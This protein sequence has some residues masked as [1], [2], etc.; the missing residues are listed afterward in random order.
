MIIDSRTVPDDETIKTDVCIV[1][2]GT[3]GITL[4][5]EF[6]DQ[7]F[8][9]C[10][11]E[12]GGLKPDRETQA[13]YQGE[14]IGHPYYS[15]D[16]AR[17]RYFGGTTNR[18]H[19]PIGDDC[20]GVRMHPLDAID[21]EKRNWV[22][23]SGWPFDKSHLD[24]YYDKA[25]ENC[26]ITPAAYG[27]TDW[28]NPKK[29]PS[30]PFNR[31]RVKTVIFK[32]GSRH[33]F[34]DGYATEVAQAENIT[35]YL[36]SNVIEIETN[37]TAHTITRL[38]VACLEGN[39]FWVRA[40]RI[41]L[42]AGAIEIPRLLLSSNRT[43]KAGLGNQHDLV[44][45]FFME[46]PHFSSGFFVPSVPGIFKFTNLYEHIHR[47]NGVPIIGKLSLSEKVLRQE[48]LLNYV[49][50]LS[51]RIA[52][53]TSLNQFLYPR[54]ES[55]SVHSY[56]ALRFAM[57]QRK[58]PDDLGSH[59]RN[60]FSGF[61]DFTV[62]AYRNIK[63]RVLRVLDKRR[64]RLFRLDNMTEQAPNPDSRVTLGSDRDSLGQ[65]RVRL[66]WRLSDFDM[67]SFIKSQE[68]VDQELRRAG[69]G[70][71]YVKPI[72][73]IPPNQITGGWHHMGTTRMHTDPKYGVVDQ[74]CRVHG[75][76][77]LFIAGPS[78]FPTSGFANPS[79]TIIALAV[80]LADH[81][82]RLMA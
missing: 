77:N 27:V 57:G 26:K 37:E 63:K 8:R 5:K 75:I 29:T 58:L 68:I 19:I 65:R 35:T 24:P 11:L 6:I 82:K 23:F 79:L 22:P 20:S 13:L 25:Q 18:W 31:D 40:K 61:D 34:L 54:I 52:L 32:F 67:E 78:V 38:R 14:N 1:G 39:K 28:E 51:P 60:I 4:A 55:K 53:K 49:V 33:P 2:A 7:K 69:L 81:I 42:A 17:A 12:S 41:I 48:K 73:E 70:R 15:L 44:G 80:R 46:H 74:N 47:V 21:F 62:T 30:L 76:S 64:I 72:D 66:D 43:Q 9:V 71:L 36:Y 45:R 56:K 3:A 50:E 10:I 16:S 59:L